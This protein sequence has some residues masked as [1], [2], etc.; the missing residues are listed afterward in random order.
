[1]ERRIGGR[2]RC[3]WAP[4]DHALGPGVQ[5]A[6][7]LPALP[8]EPPSQSHPKCTDKKE[9]QPLAL[10]PREGGAGAVMVPDGTNRRRKPRRRAGRRRAARRHR[11]PKREGAG[12]A[13]S[14]RTSRQTEGGRPRQTDIPACRRDGV[15]AASGGSAIDCS[16]WSAHACSAGTA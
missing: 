7:A 8:A 5:L 15:L 1:M 13:M 11:G 2:Q 10:C 3:S 6:P 9:M 4:G 16:G 12:L 14:A